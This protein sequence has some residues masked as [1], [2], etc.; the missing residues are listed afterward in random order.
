MEVSRAECGRLVGYFSIYKSRATLPLIFLIQKIYDLTVPL[1][2]VFDNIK[3]SNIIKNGTSTKCIHTRNKKK[4]IPTFYAL[5]KRDFLGLFW[6]S[7]SGKNGAG[8]R[9]HNFPD[10]ATNLLFVL[11]ATSKPP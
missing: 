5:I 2:Y 3:Y 8:I 4:Q 7:C 1:Q 9:F 10:A 6:D 11:S